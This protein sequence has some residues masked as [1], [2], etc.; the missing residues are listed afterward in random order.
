MSRG[1]PPSP[2]RDEPPATDT[3]KA[4]AAAVLLVIP[5]I[6]LLAVPTYAKEDP[7]LFGFPF[8]YWYQFLWV[9]ICSGMTWTAYKLMLAAR[10]P[11]DGDR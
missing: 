9:F 3:G 7:K 2:R 10:R 8:F 11:K 6:A 5:V 4:V 1:N